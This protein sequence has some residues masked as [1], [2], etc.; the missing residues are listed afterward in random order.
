MSTDPS[1]AHRTAAMGGMIMAAEEMT[2]L[3]EQGDAWRLMGTPAVRYGETWWLG[4]ARIFVR[5]LDPAMLADLDERARDAPA[6]ER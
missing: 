4:D 2:R 5:V 3:V 1:E 6:C